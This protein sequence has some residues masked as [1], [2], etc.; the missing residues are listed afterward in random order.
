M[1][2]STQ[3]DHGMLL[4]CEDDV[5]FFSNGGKDD[6]ERWIF[7]HWCS[8]TGRNA[9]Q[10]KKGEAPDFTLNGEM[11]EIVEVLEP[12]RK[13]HKEFEDD[14]ATLRNGPSESDELVHQ[15]PELETIKSSAHKWLLEAIRDKHTHYGPTCVSWTL[16]VYA[17]F[18]FADLADWQA[19]TMELSRTPPG[20][21]RI[22]VLFPDGAKSKTLH[23]ALP[24]HQP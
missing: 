24:P 19:V 16:L 2:Q 4:A 14:L 10:G 5:R 15:G 13:R 3:P 6:R 21:A 11:I 7:H 12:D 9:V 1:S 20:F 17:D 18:S 23:T 22:E 8:L